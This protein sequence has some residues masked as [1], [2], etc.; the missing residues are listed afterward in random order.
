MLTQVALAEECGRLYG[1]ADSEEVVDFE[2][3]GVTVVVWRGRSVCPWL[4]ESLGRADAQKELIWLS[5]GDRLSVRGCWA[6]P[7]MNSP[8]LNALQKGLPRQSS[9]RAK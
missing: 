5:Y 4:G 7:S 9:G 1:K 8:K 3:E 6:F 2:G